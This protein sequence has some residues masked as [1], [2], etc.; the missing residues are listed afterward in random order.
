MTFN[1]IK[2]KIYKLSK[3]NATSYPIAD[4]VIDAN[5]A[6]DR[7]VSIIR[8]SNRLWKWD[9]SNQTDLPRATTDLVSGQQD[10]T[11]AE[12]HLGFTRV[13]VKGP[14]GHWIALKLFDETDEPTVSIAELETQTGTP[15]Y[16]DVSG[17]SIYLYPTPNYSQDDSIQL[18]YSR[19]PSYFTSGDTTKQPGFN[20]LY[21]EL[22]PYLVATDKVLMDIPQLAAGYERKV[23]RLEDALKRDY[24]YRGPGRNRF[25][26]A[27]RRVG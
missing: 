7:C 12:A 14:D 5:N 20:S 21:H 1:D 15:T 11:L 2:A 18:F 27:A 8:S 10:Y 26:A 23:L 22:I 16:Y 17:L 3:T 4:L 25:T 6:Y 9:D 24:A 19:G 13:E